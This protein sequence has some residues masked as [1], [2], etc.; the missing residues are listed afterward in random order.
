MKSKHSDYSVVTM[1]GNNNGCVG[2]GFCRIFATGKFQTSSK[3]Y[4]RAVLLWS[5]PIVLATTLPNKEG[6]WVFKVLLQRFCKT[7]YSSLQNSSHTTGSG[8]WWLRSAVWLK[9]NRDS[10]VL[11]SQVDTSHCLSLPGA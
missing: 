5:R 2:T 9:N 4:D 7:L 10:F 3:C 8:R 6:S 1:H 11:Q